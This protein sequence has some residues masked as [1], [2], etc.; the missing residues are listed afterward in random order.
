[1][2]TLPLPRL[3]MAR[4]AALLIV[5]GLGCAHRDRVAPALPPLSTEPLGPGDKI[6]HINGEP[7]NDD[8]GI[9]LKG[10]QAQDEVVYTV[11]R[12]DGRIERLGPSR[13]NQRP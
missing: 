3:R 1:M 5:T 13:L 6:T 2:T 12:K 7:V 4:I 9:A 11:K 8:A 10:V